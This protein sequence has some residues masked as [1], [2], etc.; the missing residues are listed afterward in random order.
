MLSRHAGVQRWWAVWKDQ[1]CFSPSPAA[2]GAGS[3]KDSVGIAGSRSAVNSVQL[4]VGR[5]SWRG[6][7]YPIRLEGLCMPQAGPEAR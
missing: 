5:S 3:G 7:G 1:C 2:L 6:T 4:G